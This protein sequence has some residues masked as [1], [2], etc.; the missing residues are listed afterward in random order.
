MRRALD[1]SQEAVVA[2]R[3]PLPQIAAIGLTVRTNPKLHRLHRDGRRYVVSLFLSWLPASE[4]DL[5]ASRMSRSSFIVV[6]NFGLLR[7]GPNPCRVECTSVRARARRQRITSIA[8]TKPRARAGNK[9]M[10]DS[11]SRQRFRFVH[12]RAYIAAGLRP[13]RAR[14]SRALIP[15]RCARTTPA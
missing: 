1:R 13:S 4:E 14:R 10:H 3:S 5:S 9:S 8:I 7:S 15:S 2:V 11:I 6:S 12:Q